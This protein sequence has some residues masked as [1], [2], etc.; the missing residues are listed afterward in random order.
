VCL[1]AFSNVGLEVTF[2]FEGELYLDRFMEEPIE[3]LI[4]GDDESRRRVLDRITLQVQRS[5]D[6][7]KRTLPFVR[8]GRVFVAPLPAPLPLREHLAANIGEPVESLDLSSV[9]DFGRV[10]EL[11]EEEMQ[12]RFL[13]PLGA[14]LRT[15]EKR[16]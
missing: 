7:V 1:I 5:L 2:T 11:R 6:F 14:A 15:S 13:V 4:S 3:P 10:P 16:A 12:A 8:V 9:F